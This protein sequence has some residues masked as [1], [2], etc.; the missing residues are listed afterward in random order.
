MREVARQLASKGNTAQ[1]DR[2]KIWLV[3]DQR[4]FE[5]PTYI[6]TWV[7]EG[8]TTARKVRWVGT[9]LGCFINRPSPL[10]GSEQCERYGRSDL[11]GCIGSRQIQEVSIETWTNYIQMFIASASTP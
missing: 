3:V 10:H 5:R 6:S 8:N 11:L 2:P 1:V 7:K 4:G 9:V